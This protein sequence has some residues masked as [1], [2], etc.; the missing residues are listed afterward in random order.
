MSESTHRKVKTALDETRLLIL[1]VHILLGFHLNAAFQF[2]FAHSCSEF[3][4]RSGVNGYQAFLATTF[5]LMV[6]ACGANESVAACAVAALKDVDAAR[7]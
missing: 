5:A 2:G 6:L 3:R 7:T 1:G 4:N